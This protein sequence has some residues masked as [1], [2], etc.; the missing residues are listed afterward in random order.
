MG[1][2][3]TRST[4]SI[5]N[6]SGVLIR[7]YGRGEGLEAPPGYDRDSLVDHG[8]DSISG[9]TNSDVSSPA[10]EEWG[11]IGGLTPPGNPPPEFMRGNINSEGMPDLSR[12]TVDRLVQS[13]K[14]NINNMHPILIPSRLDGLVENFMKTMPESHAKPKQVSALAGHLQSHHGPAGFISRNPDSPGNKRKRSPGLQE[15]QEMPNF[16]DTKPGHPFR[17]IGS[18]LVLLVLALGAITQHKGKLPDVAAD[19][20]DDISWTASPTVRNG[21]PPSP[22]Q[23]SPSITTPLAE[24]SP[25]EHDRTQSRSRRTSIEGVYPPKRIPTVKEKNLDRIPGLFYFAFAT[26]IIGNQ[27]GGNSLPHVHANILAGLYQGQLGRV[28]ESHAYITSACRGLQVLLRPRLDRFRKIKEGAGVVS[29]KENPLVIAFWT[30]LQLER[31]VAKDLIHQM[32][33]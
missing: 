24:S 30:C 32:L 23:S 9:D 19:R 10:G 12:D 26:D 13:Y 29:S 28:L 3:R 14:D 22:L 33:Y 27:L 6:R 5:K 18:A 25:Q 2:S 16:Y 15:N 11:Q 7:L 8:N 21:Y 31:Y 17:S 4:P 20:D 1:R